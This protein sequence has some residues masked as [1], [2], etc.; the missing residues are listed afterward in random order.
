MKKLILGL[1]VGLMIGTAGTAIAAQDV[2]QAVKAKFEIVVNGQTQQ[3]ATEPVV[4]NGTSYLPLRAAAGLFGYQ[5]DFKDG[6]ILLDNGDDTMATVTDTTT[7][8]NGRTLIEILSQKYSLTHK[9][10][11]SLTQ[12][13]VLSI[14]G[15]TY[16]L[17][18]ND[19]KYDLTSLLDSG[20]LSQDDLKNYSQ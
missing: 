5:V 2:L 4:I 10:D 17:S 14:N 1:L 12:D 18:F 19:G 8:M 9:D 6:K 7:E 13:G 16:N 15:L 11:L 20:V 3:L